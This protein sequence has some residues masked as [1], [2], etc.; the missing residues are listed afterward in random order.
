MDIPALPTNNLYKFSALCGLLLVV[1]GIGYPTNKIFE[2]E[3][4]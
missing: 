3:P 1:L 4:H 2:I